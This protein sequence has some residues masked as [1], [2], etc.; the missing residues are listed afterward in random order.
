M[1]KMGD[2]ELIAT[3]DLVRYNNLIPGFDSWNFISFTENQVYL[4][5]SWWVNITYLY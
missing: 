2:S 3:S 4:L 5:W 1:K